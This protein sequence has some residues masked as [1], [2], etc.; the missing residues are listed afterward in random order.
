[1]QQSNQGSVVGNN[2]H[3]NYSLL[4]TMDFRAIDEMDPSLADGHRVMYDR[5][6][7]FELRTQESCQKPHD[8]GTLESVKTKVLVLGEDNN[9]LSLRIELSSESDLFFHYTCNINYNG[10]RQLQEEQKLTCEFKEFASI[11]LRMLN[12]CI[13]E[14]QCFLAVLILTSDGNAVLEFIQNMEYKFVELLVLPFKESPEYVIRQHIS[15]RYNSLRSRLAMMHARLQDVNALVKIKN[16]SLL[17]H[18]QRSGGTGAV[19][20]ST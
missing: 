20:T 14:P 11:L 5:E 15:Y 10:F 3:N 8:V 1:M 4:S 9:I 13:K 6:V 19:N 2:E 18:L 7:P 16:P 17:L 12:R